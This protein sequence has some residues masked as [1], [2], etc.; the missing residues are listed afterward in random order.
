MSD[1]N[2]DAKSTRLQLSLHEHGV[3]F[4]W[5][6]NSTAVLHADLDLDGGALI[7]G[8]FRGNL[9]S[10]KGSVVITRTGRFIGNLEADRIYVEGMIGDLEFPDGNI[11]GRYSLAASSTASIMANMRARAYAIHSAR[12]FGKMEPF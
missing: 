5:P 10:R 2:N 3:I 12:M 7:A 11:V 4:M 6:P 8:E 9:I 1:P